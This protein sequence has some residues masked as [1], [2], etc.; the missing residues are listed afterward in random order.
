MINR[1]VRLVSDALVDLL[2]QPTQRNGATETFGDFINLF[3]DHLAPKLMGNLSIPVDRIKQKVSLGVLAEAE[4]W[5]DSIN[6]I[7]PL[8]IVK[9]AKHCPRNEMPSEANKS[10]QSTL[11]Q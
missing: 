2:F 8:T 7:R 5:R 10:P 4:H 9:E 6:C 11:Q 1:P 3:A